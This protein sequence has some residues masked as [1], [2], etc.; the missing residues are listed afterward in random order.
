[1]VIL[2]LCICLKIHRMPFHGTTLFLLISSLPWGV[3]IK[4]L[5]SICCL[6]PTDQNGSAYFGAL[7]GRVANRVADA[8][9]VLDGKVYHLYRN[10]GKN[11]LHG[12]PQNPETSKSRSL[13]R[14]NSLV[15]HEQ[16]LNLPCSYS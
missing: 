2:P 5:T 14:E 3:K 15:L 1:M 9:F 11:A 6:N 12:T 13:V 4:L 7:V 16:W 8:R 10:D